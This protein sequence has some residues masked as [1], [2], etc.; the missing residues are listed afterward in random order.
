LW[1]IFKQKPFR[2]GEAVTP[3]LAGPFMCLECQVLQALCYV[4][5]L[6][7]Y[8]VAG[9]STIARRFWQ[10]CKPTLSIGG[11]AHC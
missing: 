2:L 4:L 9:N 11:Q 7:G 6:Q 5:Q 3:M 1:R 8:T 10:L